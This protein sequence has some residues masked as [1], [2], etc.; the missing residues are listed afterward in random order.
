M[1]LSSTSTSSCLLQGLP[2]FGA[3][4]IPVAICVLI[5][6]AT[7]ASV[8][9]SLLRSGCT[10]DS[11]RKTSGVEQ[12]RR[13]VTISVFLGLTWILG[14][15]AVGDAKLVFQYLFCV[16]NSLQGWLIFLFYC[17]FSTEVR[18]KVCKQFS[19]S[20]RTALTEALGPM[21]SR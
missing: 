10:I 20:L 12:A 7:F 11:T 1:T 15:L 3:F 19:K 2:L 18:G 13:G 6:T 17:V 21:R 8:L 14:V 4:F 9:K 5:N 16:V